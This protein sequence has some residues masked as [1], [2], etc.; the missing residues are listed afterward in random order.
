MIVKISLDTRTFYIIVL[1]YPYMYGYMY[2]ICLFFYRIELSDA[3]KEISYL[4]TQVDSL[5]AK[6]AASRSTHTSTSV[7]AASGI[8]GTA[9]SSSQEI[10]LSPAVISSTSDM[11][12]GIASESPTQPSGLGVGTPAEAA[13]SGGPVLGSDHVPVIAPASSRLPASRTDPGDSAVNVDVG[14]VQNRP[15]AKAA[16][17]SGGQINSQDSP[18]SITPSAR[19]LLPSHIATNQSS[20]LGLSNQNTADIGAF[21]D[22]RLGSASAAAGQDSIPT[23][24][25]ATFPGSGPSSGY[26]SG[27]LSIDSAG[28]YQSDDQSS[29]QEYVSNMPVN[30]AV[31]AQETGGRNVDAARQQVRQLSPTPGPS[32]ERDTTAANKRSKSSKGVVKL[33]A[34]GPAECSI[35]NPEIQGSPESGPK[36]GHYGGHAGVAASASVSSSSKCLNACR[37]DV[38]P[39]NDRSADTSS[40]SASGVCVPPP[41]AQGFSG[42]ALKPSAPTPPPPN[43]SPPPPPPRMTG[44]QKTPQPSIASDQ[45]ARSAISAIS[46]P[47]AAAPQKP[48]PPTR[49][50]PNTPKP[51]TGAI[52]AIQDKIAN[53]SECEQNMTTRIN[54]KT[55]ACSATTKSIPVTLTNEALLVT[56]V[57]KKL[58]EDENEESIQ[59][60]IGEWGVPNL[61]QNTDEVSDIRQIGPNSLSC[62]LKASSQST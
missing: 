34:S 17:G 25:N 44:N 16:A 9:G 38:L 3:R 55:A 61:Q 30:R 31:P 7:T 41:N 33:T 54:L 22:A 36:T 52:C 14:A 32:R 43:S 46:G 45:L 40:S 23:A 50:K 26:L 42:V 10:S 60:S 19:E 49:P 20:Q 51:N 59:T 4:K 8:A 6:L 11:R 18:P 1:Y 5:E 15:A 48:M 53:A 37:N 57:P 27:N 13:A 2:N 12:M 24:L 56:G 29:T 58:W 62:I 28:G 47:G 35:I 39:K 21:I